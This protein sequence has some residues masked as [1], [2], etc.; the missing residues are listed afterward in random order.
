MPDYTA[1]ND[2][3]DAL[4][5]R[6]KAL[7][8]ELGKLQAEA[9]IVATLGMAGVSAG[10]DAVI[11]PTAPEV[12]IVGGTATEQFPDCC[13]V[14]NAQGFFCS[15]TLIAPRVVVTADHCRQVD[16]IFLKG[17]DITR[18]HE[19]EVIAVL[20]QVSHPEVDLSVL[21]LAHESTVTPRSVAENL[22]LAGITMVTVAGFGTID[23]HGIV[24]YGV[25][26]MVDVPIMTVDCSAPDDPKHYGCLPG[27]E[28]V[29]GHRGLLRDS[30]RGDSGGPLYIKIADSYFLLGLTSRGVRGGFTACGDGGIYVRVDRCM[31]WVRSVADM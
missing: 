20:R 27:R 16:R 24:G 2:L 8:D 22:D 31:G 23:L 19:G 7:R 28:I 21:I 4:E 26:R 6:V 3:V 11:P 18:P 15:G 13:A 1:M 30:C 12:E 9:D 25:K 29:A 10:P 17:S 14:G 5:Q